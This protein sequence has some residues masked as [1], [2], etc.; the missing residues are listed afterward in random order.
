MKK[1]TDFNLSSFLLYSIHSIFF[2]TI[3]IFYTIYY[4]IFLT[5][6]KIL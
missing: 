5:N 6:Y 1:A 4:T 3:A 2:Y